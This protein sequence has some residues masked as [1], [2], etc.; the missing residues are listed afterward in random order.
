MKAAIL[1]FP[2]IHNGYLNFIKSIDDADKIFVM[3]SAIA[4]E[5]EPTLQKDIRALKSYQMVKFLNGSGLLSCDTEELLDQS[6]LDSYEQIVMPDE[7]VSHGFVKKF[8]DDTKS[9]E[10]VNVFLRWDKKRSSEESEA[11]ENFTVTS[12][13]FDRKM[14]SACKKVA[15]RS[16]D[17]W[18]QVG[19][20]IVK[21]GSLIL[22]AVHN[23]HVPSLDQ[24]Y[25]DGDPRSN[26]RAGNS[27]ELGTALHVE[28]NLISMAAE[29]GISLSGSHLYVTTF[30]CPWC[31]KAIA[32]SGIERV[33]FEEGYA[34]LD[35]QT[36][37][38]AN[39]VEIV[40]VIK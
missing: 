23:I 5:L 8:F 40:R 31:A 22:P 18:R 1:Y 21:N 37:L 32:Y 29:V 14:I 7:E 12:L 17:W 10:F 34:V 11:V 2:V 39:G 16:G 13:E 15:S 26:F 28:L 35:A 9:V 6:A 25:Y 30:P 3:S 38:E 27:V 36:I 4:I 20:C 19:G 24:A 33:Y